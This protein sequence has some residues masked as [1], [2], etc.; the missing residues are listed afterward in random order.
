MGG[1]SEE[2]VGG[3]VSSF[4][5]GYEFRGEMEASLEFIN[6]WDTSIM[7]LIRKMNNRGRRNVK[8]CEVVWLNTWF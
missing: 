7:C 4:G 8:I 2:W 3:G 1:K 6:G 5:V